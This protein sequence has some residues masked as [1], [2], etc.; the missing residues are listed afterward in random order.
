MLSCHLKNLLSDPNTSEWRFNGGER[1]LLPDRDGRPGSLSSW[2][3]IAFNCVW[4]QI[5]LRPGGGPRP[6]VARQEPL[7]R[8]QPV[9]SRGSPRSA[10]IFATDEQAPVLHLDFRD[11]LGCV[12]AAGRL[13][14]RQGQGGPCDE[15]RKQPRGFRRNPGAPGL[16]NH[17]QTART[18]TSRRA[19]ASR[20]C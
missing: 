9:L 5:W 1:A 18:T 20:A 8:D 14:P 15:G 19:R 4:I 3:P 7:S 6:P 17:H 13:F 16:D 2:P 12:C 11:W 10:R